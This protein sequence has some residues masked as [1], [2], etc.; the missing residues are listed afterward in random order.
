[1]DRTDTAICFTGE[2]GGIALGIVGALL[3][4]ILVYGAHARN[5]TAILIWM[6]FAILQ[7]IGTVIVA[8]YFA[9]FFVGANKKLTGDALIIC[10][11]LII[12]IVVIILFEIC[13][14]IVAQNARKE[15][16]RDQRKNSPKPMVMP[17]ED[18]NDGQKI[19]NKVII[20]V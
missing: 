5:H 15:I 2:Y 7:C 9:I 12:Y 17:F 14:I 18:S 19:G 13:T 10:I 4:A 11:V 16:Q 20:G 8:I 3:S 6:I 1:M